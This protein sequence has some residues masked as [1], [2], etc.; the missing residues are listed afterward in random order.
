[1]NARVAEPAHEEDACAAA[2]LLRI[3]GPPGPRSLVK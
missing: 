3:R 1:M 2:A